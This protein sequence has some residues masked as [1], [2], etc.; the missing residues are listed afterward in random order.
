MITGLSILLL[1]DGN[2]NLLVYVLLDIVDKHVFDNADYTK[3][4]H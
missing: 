4:C 3:G 2:Y 1:Q